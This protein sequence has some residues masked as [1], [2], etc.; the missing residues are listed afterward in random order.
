MYWGTF[1]HGNPFQ[2]AKHTVMAGLKWPPDVGAHMRI[3]KAIPMAN[4]QPIWKIELILGLA[5]LRT[6]PAIEEHPAYLH[7]ED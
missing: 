5:P 4:A 3:A 2:I 6:K 7:Y 1:R